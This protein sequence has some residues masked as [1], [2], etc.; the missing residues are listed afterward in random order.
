MPFYAHRVIKVQIFPRTIGWAD[1]EA[2]MAP[3]P[4]HGRHLGHSLPFN[5]GRRARARSR[6]PRAR[7]HVA[8]GPHAPAAHCVART[9]AAAA[10][11]FLLDC[12]L[13]RGG[14]RRPLVLDVDVGETH[15]EL[16]D[17]SAHLRG[18]AV[19]GGG[20]TNTATRR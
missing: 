17:Q 4:G 5:P 7:P 8:D 11:E 20:P 16:T 3:L 12:H 15:H 19:R 2:R 10:E 9:T 13:R 1:V 18:A 6:R 14:V